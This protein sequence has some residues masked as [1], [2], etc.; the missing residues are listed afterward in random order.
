MR[1]S[2]LGLVAWHHSAHDAAGGD[3]LRAVRGDPIAHALDARVREPFAVRS[4]QPPNAAARIERT[5]SA[6]PCNPTALTAEEKQ[7]RFGRPGL[8]KCAAKPTKAG[9]DRCHERLTGRRARARGARAPASVSGTLRAYENRP[10]AMRRPQIRRDPGKLDL[11]HCVLVPPRS[12]ERRV[13]HSDSQLLEA[14][15]ASTFGT[16]EKKLSNRLGGS[17]LGLEIGLETELPRTGR[18]SGTPSAVPAI[19]PVGA[20]VPPVL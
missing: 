20:V 15:G 16:I 19:Q 6:C 3:Q 7:P 8:R 1:A 18:F 13:S 10:R 17:P 12:P 9:A 4:S 14:R 11:V 2:P 5:S